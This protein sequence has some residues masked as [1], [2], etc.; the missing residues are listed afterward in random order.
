MFSL[1][2]SQNASR[3]TVGA[4]PES[5]TQPGYPACLKGKAESKVC[6]RAGAHHQEPA[7]TPYS[8]RGVY[9]DWSILS[10]N[11]L[12]RIQIPAGTLVTIWNEQHVLML[13]CRRNVDVFT[14]GCI[15]LSFPKRVHVDWNWPIS[16][17]KISKIRL[18]CKNVVAVGYCGS[19]RLLI[20]GNCGPPGGAYP[21]F[22]SMKQ[23]GV[24]SS[25]VIFI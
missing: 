5:S 11:C 17:K 23:V 12:F 3:K 24:K 15:V 13:T 8:S 2:F 10:L 18:V 22:C 1:F 6:V 7:P 14:W 19:Y 25:Q 4:V 21:G 9:T 16:R 20:L